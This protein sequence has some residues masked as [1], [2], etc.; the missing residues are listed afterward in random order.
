MAGMRNAIGQAFIIL[1]LSM[2]L[3][4]GSYLSRS[5]AVPAEVG[6]HEITLEAARAL[7]EAL[8]VDARIDA[9]FQERHYEGAI[10]V[11][12]EDW[13]SGFAGLLAVWQPGTPIVVYCSTQACLRSHHVAER[14]R[15]ELGVEEGIYT[16][17]GGWEALVDANLVEGGER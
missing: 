13:E 15:D 12:E 11:N 14:L 3:A 17:E 5:D 16:L 6:E 9:D 1:G 2:V 7:D 10:L 8:W 4:L